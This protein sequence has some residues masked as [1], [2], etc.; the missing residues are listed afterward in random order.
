MI[1]TILVSCSTFQ[2]PIA[3]QKLES[4][5]FYK[6]D[7]IING[8][9]GIIVLPKQQAYDMKIEAR[10]DLDLFIMTT[11]SRE[12][13]K[14]KAKLDKARLRLKLLSKNK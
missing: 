3:N 10:G 4:S 6:R 12:Y 13:T 1:L 14:E 7:M 2:P 5:K 8:N 9:E 11:C